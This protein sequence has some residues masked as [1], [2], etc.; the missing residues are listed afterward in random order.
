MA[1][2][3]FWSVVAM[4]LVSKKAAVQKHYLLLPLYRQGQPSDG[5]GLI[6]VVVPNLSAN[7]TQLISSGISQNLSCA[8]D[9]SV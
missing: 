2:D 6:E 7:P 4:I 9:D 8:L 1:H 3:A 5:F